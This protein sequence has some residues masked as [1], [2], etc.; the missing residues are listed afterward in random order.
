MNGDNWICGK[1]IKLK[2]QIFI[3]RVSTSVVT[4]H[5]VATGCDN[6]TR[7]LAS[8]TFHVITPAPYYTRQLIE[9][10]I[11]TMERAP[12]TTIAITVRYSGAQSSRS[13]RQKRELQSQG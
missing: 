8:C 9:Y 6:R 12:K 2:P 7:R 1:L 3:A 10:L 4:V 5:T 13:A 11:D